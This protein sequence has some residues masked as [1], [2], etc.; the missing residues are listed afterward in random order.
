M[1]SMR[2][3]LVLVP[4]LLCDAD[5]WRDQMMDLTDIADPV[6]TLESFQHTSME[7][8]A[9]AILAKAPPQFA[10]AGLSM[11]G[12]ISEAIMRLAPERVVKLALL[13]TGPRADTPE[14]TAARK[15]LIEL[16]QIGNFKGVTPRLLPRLVHPDRLND[17]PLISRITAMADHVGKDGF[18]RQQTAIMGREDQ[19]PH[20]PG[21][22][23]PTLILVGRQDILT[24][25]ELHEE[26][27][28]LIPGAKLVVVENCG[29]MSTM[30]RPDAVNAALRK[31][32][33]A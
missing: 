17:E 32:L 11:G 22:K 3:P 2:I 10:L 5:L 29:H 30:E 16:A 21:Y 13:D 1:A 6:V 28:S 26:M 19:R 15:G 18:L 33:K 27:A 24:P 31:W 12:Y 23:C 25:L 20:M 14:Q 8:I 7:A 4:G 9:R